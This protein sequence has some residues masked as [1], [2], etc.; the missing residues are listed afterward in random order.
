[1]L[2][3][4]LLKDLMADLKA[5]STYSRLKRKEGLFSGAGLRHLSDIS[6]KPG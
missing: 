2:G 4:D 6:Q 1:M 3:N 5:G